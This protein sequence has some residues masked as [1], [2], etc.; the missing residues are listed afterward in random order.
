M[1]RPQFVFSAILAASVLAGPAHAADLVSFITPGADE[2][3]R[4]TLQNASLSREAGAAK[5]PN[6]QDLFA[7]A[8]AD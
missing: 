3:L 4:T 6:A 5:S 1:R 8:R 2:A 7:S